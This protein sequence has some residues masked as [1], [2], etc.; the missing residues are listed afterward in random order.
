VTNLLN[1]ASFEGG[2]W[3]KTHT[4]QEFG[5]IFVPE[6]WVAYWSAE[7]TVP[8]D[9]NNTVGY[10]RPEMHVINREPPFLD[11][12]R[13][14]SGNR[15]LK[16]FTFWRIHD[17]G[18]YQQVTGVTPGAT[19]EATAQAQAWSSQQDDAHTSD[20]AGT[21][22]FFK[23]EGQTDNAVQRNFTFKV[24]I[25]PTGGTDP[26][27]DSVV[28]GQG[29]HIYNVYAQVPAVQ[30]TAQGTKVTVFLRSTV[31][32]PYKH[33][34]AYWDAASLKVVTGGSGGGSIQ[35]HFDPPAVQQEKVFEVVARP[36][37]EVGELRLA[38]E[39]PDE[40]L[41][42]RPRLRTNEVRWRCVALK[43]GDVTVKLFSGATQL[44]Q[45]TF[46]TLARPSFVPPREDYERVYVL[47]PPSAGAEWVK[48]V[49][50]SSGWAAQRWTVGSSA[51]DAG[52]GPSRRKVI[53]VNPQG[54]PS[55]LQAF[56]N[57]HY[58]GVT[59][60]ALNAASPA[61]LKALLSR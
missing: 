18:I 30:A 6:G 21:G 23:L 46:T 11:P 26:W 45:A 44:D 7:K 54:W 17:A 48:V 41:V 39:G 14:H 60:E 15:A 22:A 28:W 5:E 12:L 1:N 3:R 20:G 10:G 51:D 43:P 32:W 59:Y 4:G 47:L 49:V 56:F 37:S 25:D 19:L 35:L 36:A 33:C 16:F 61:E 57:Q 38:F 34:D 24:G 53:A 31:L 58:P 52:V 29:A 27:A 8:H 2:W 55:N 40:V 9:P 42:G 13:V 50:E